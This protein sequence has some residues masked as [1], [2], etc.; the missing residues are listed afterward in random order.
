MVATTVHSSITVL[1]EIFKILSEVNTTKHIPRRLDDAFS[2]C[3]D[4]AFK[5]AILT[6]FK[7]Q[8]KFHDKYVSTAHWYLKFPKY[9]M[10]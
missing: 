2:V 8:T 10:F 1:S 4:R 7:I 3:G 6:H 9:P 5:L